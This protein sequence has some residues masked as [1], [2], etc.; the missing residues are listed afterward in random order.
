MSNCIAN[1]LKTCNNNGLGLKSVYLFVYDFSLVFNVFTNIHEYANMQIRLDNLHMYNSMKGLCLN[2]N[3]VPD[4][5]V[6][7]R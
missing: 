5:V 2:F 7:D 3:L 1:D 4:S 6:Y